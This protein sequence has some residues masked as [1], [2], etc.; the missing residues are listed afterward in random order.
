[1]ISTVA[2]A[3]YSVKLLTASMGDSPIATSRTIQQE[4]TGTNAALAVSQG[5]HSIADALAWSKPSW[6]RYRAISPSSPTQTG[7]L[8]MAGSAVA[9]SITNSRRRMLTA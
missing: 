4:A 5:D 3:E 7:P 9:T 1:L 2:T 6:V 8:E